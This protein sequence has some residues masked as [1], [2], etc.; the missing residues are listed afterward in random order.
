MCNEADIATSIDGF[1]GNRFIF[2]GFSHGDVDCH[3]TTN[4][5]FI[6]SNNSLLFSNSLFYSCACLTAR[7][8]GPELLTQGCSTFIGYRSSVYVNEDYDKVFIKCKN[9]GIKKFFEGKNTIKESYE[10]MRKTYQN[11]IDALIIGDADDF[12]AASSLS[13]NL[14]ALV[15]KGNETLTLPDFFVA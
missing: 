6:S 14:K 2:I 3:A 9:S 10:F 4:E 13:G 1:N 15:F 12:F 11:E 5:I 8:L 7:K